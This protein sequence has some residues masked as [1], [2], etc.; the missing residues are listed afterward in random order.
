MRFV[1]RR[2]E[3][4]ELERLLGSAAAGRGGA[5]VVDGE[6]GIGKSMLIDTAVGMLDGFEVLRAAGAEFEQDLLYAV[7]HQ[8]CAPVLEHRLKLPAVQ[9]AALEAVFGLEARI[10][11]DSLTVN[12]ADLGLLNEAAR[13]RPVCCVVDD[14]QWID[15]ASRRVLV[16]VAR[17]VA[18]NRIAM[19]FAAPPSTPK[20]NG[21]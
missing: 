12:P 10:S 5:L 15:E 13:E 7:L 16:F 19:V 2:A 1:V 17:R 4:R 18:D 14:A 21:S 20:P 11:A 9:R 6:A 3:L 8:L